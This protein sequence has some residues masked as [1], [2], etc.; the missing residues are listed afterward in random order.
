M[1]EYRKGNIFRS[2][3]DVLVNPVNCSGDSSRGL[4]LNFS[5]HFPENG[6]WLRQIACYRRLWPGEL[7]IW[8]PPVRMLGGPKYIFNIF[9]KER[10]QDGTSLVVIVACLEAIL[11]SLQPISRRYVGKVESIAIPA[12]GCGSSGLDWCT[13]RYLMETLAAPNTRTPPM[14]WLVY[15]PARGKTNN[16]VARQGSIPAL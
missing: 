9:T 4:A 11:N 12:L 6:R 1:I 5:K 7:M 10:R 2:G 16:H 8:E 3:A 13:V 14:R 15:A